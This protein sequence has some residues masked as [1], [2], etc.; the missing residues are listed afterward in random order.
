MR[1]QT[2][3]IIVTL[4]AIAAILTG[5]K[6]AEVAVAHPMAGIYVTAKFVSHDV[7]PPKYPEAITSEPAYDSELMSLTAPSHVAHRLPA[8]PAG[9]FS[10]QDAS[11]GR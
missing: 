5:C 2:S 8:D 10:T 4:L 3:F 7:E 1:H 11:N 9:S 6:T